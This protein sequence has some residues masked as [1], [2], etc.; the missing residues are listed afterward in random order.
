MALSRSPVER[1]SLIRPAAAVCALVATLMLARPHS[2]GASELLTNGGFEEGTAGW[3]TNAGQ[4]DSVSSPLH[5]GSQAGRFSGSGQP[6]TQFAYQL[7]NVQPASNYELS[8]WVA[9]PASGVSRVFLRVSWFD[10]SGSLV[11]S[12]DSP[13]LAQPDGAFHP[14]ATGAMVSPVAA[15]QA[16]ANILIQ[17]DSPFSVHPDDFAFS[18]PALVPPPPS[19]PP[20]VPTSPPQITPAP[21]LAPPGTTPGPL[22]TPTRTPGRGPTP[23]ATTPATGN[24]EPDSFPQLV[25]GGFEDLRSDGTPYAW[26]KQGGEMSTVTEPRTE[27][28]RALVLASQTSSTK[29]VYQTVS[30]QPRAYYEASVQALAGPRADSAFLRLS[31]YASGDGSGQAIAS[32][33]SLDAVSSTQGEFRRLTTG[34]VQAPDG[35]NSVKLRL[36]LRLASGEPAAAYFDDAQFG[37][38]QPAPGETVRVANGS[39][40]SGR[41]DASLAEVS[42]PEG[43]AP[44]ATTAVTLA[45]IKPSRPGASEAAASAGQGR[46]DWAILLAIA[47]ALAAIALAGGHGMWQRKRARKGRADDL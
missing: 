34:P 2:A 44:G 16:R 15:R 30:A 1:P 19:T 18:G 35:A 24:T 26:H 25:N 4:L 10:A 22:P 11:L 5:G 41:E 28:A 37:P 42:A 3:S 7:I 12:S 17:A 14:F 20:P 13:W 43:F 23:K 47:I 40:A 46:N 31:W 8:G 33:D 27:G 29:W 6:T 32:I 45:N 38:T 21:T 36:M 39:L 9:A